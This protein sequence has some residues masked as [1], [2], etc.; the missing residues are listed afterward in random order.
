VNRIQ[1][2]RSKLQNSNA[3]FGDNSMPSVLKS[4][5]SCYFRRFSRLQFAQEQRY[6]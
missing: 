2:C 1:P 4:T 5:A 6:M 3:I